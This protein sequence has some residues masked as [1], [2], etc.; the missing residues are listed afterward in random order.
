MGGDESD[1]EEESNDLD[2]FHDWVGWFG[3]WWERGLSYVDLRGSFEVTFLVEKKDHLTWCCGLG[4]K[5]RK[6]RG[7]VDQTIYTGCRWLFLKGGTNGQAQRCFFNGILTCGMLLP[8]VICHHFID[9]HSHI[10]PL[11]I[12]H[13]G[14][15]IIQ[16]RRL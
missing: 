2:R 10:V 7:R 15:G 4:L 16:K 14:I 12:F 3:M 5:K 1:G 8:V 6:K 9:T 11:C 13:T